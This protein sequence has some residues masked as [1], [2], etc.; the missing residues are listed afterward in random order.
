MPIVLAWVSSIYY[1]IPIPWYLA[2]LL[3]L[4][5]SESKCEYKIPVIE[6]YVLFTDW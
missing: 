1:E 2:S 3:S 6:M 5:G 4:V